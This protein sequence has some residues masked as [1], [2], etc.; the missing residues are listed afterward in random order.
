MNGHWLIKTGEAQQAIGISRQKFSILAPHLLTLVLAGTSRRFP[1][2]YLMDYQGHSLGE[3]LPE[4]TPDSADCYAVSD[5]AA[6]KIAGAQT[7]YI[8]DL[9]ER[10]IGD[11]VPAV[12]FR[13]VTGVGEQTLR[14]WRLNE[15]L[16]AYN[17]GEGPKRRL[18]VPLT[19]IIRISEWVLP[20]G[21]VE[22]QGG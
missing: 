13:S 14:Q 19:E 10:A 22:N 2:D 18:M 16:D 12:A 5:A 6:G 11:A 20:Q 17:I 9:A 15:Q 7:R 1:V 3:A 4:P 21:M 8:D